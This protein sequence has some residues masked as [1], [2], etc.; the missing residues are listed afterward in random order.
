[1]S[2]VA[3]TDHD[4]IRGVKPACAQ[5]QISGIKVVPGIEL[6]CGWKGR[7]ASVHVLGLFIDEDSSVLNELLE[8]QRRYRHKRA[9]KILDKLSENGVFVEPLREEF[10]KCN[11]KVLGRP[12]IARYLLETGVI[13]DFEQAFKLYLSRG[14]PAYIPKDHVEMEQGL[15]TI[16]A[17]GGIA[18]LAHPGL[19]PDWDAVWPR[20]KSLPWDGIETY[21]SEHDQQQVQKFA[22]IA[23]DLGCVS[24]GGS[25]FHGDYG[26]HRNRLGNYG[27]IREQYANLGKLL[28][29]RNSKISSDFWSEVQG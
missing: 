26:K 15:E 12:H 3:I 24:T 5:G 9:L 20:L 27:L 14:C 11:D 10:V 7:E 22:Q 21:Y 16:K 19:I 18:V 1:L 23:S 2:V 25:D 17:A 28:R 6:S 13:T 8:N 4:T 29:E